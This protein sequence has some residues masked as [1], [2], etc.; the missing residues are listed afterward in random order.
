MMSI[1]DTG[2]GPL[3]VFGYPLMR[4]YYTVF[5]F[6]KQRMGFALA[7]AGKRDHKMKAAKGSMSDVKLVGIR[8][9]F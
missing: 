2:K 1:G 4:K 9:G 8:P 6:G 7:K 5:D 3:F